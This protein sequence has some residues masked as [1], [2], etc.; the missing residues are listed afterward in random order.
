MARGQDD[1]A[2]IR[3]GAAI[4]GA[5]GQGLNP[6]SFVGQAMDAHDAGRRKILAELMDVIQGGPLQIHDRHVRAVAG[7]GVPQFLEILSYVDQ[8]EVRVKTFGQR[9]GVLAVVLKDNDTERLHLPTHPF[10]FLSR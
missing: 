5:C 1:G 7:N 3:T 2:D 6:E 10:L 4:H 9:F 8:A